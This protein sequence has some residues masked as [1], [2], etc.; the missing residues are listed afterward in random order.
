MNQISAHKYVHHFIPRLITRRVITD[1][2]YSF[3][4][5]SFLC[6]CSADGTINLWDTRKLHKPAGVAK[7]PLAAASFVRWNRRDSLLLLS[8]HEGRACVWDLRV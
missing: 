2:Q 6:S 5:A 7:F 4:D 1:L 3:M 8:A